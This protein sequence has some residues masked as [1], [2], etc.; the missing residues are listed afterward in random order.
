MTSSPRSSG[1]SL[2]L[3]ALLILAF[4]P[5]FSG[6]GA[7]ARVRQKPG[8]APLAGLRDQ[9]EAQLA[10]GRLKEARELFE[11]AVAMSPDD[12]RAQLELGLLYE[13]EGKT[14]RAIAAYEAGFRNPPAGFDRL[15][16]NLGA[17]HNLEGR[18]E[19]TLQLLDGRIADGDRDATAHLV[20]GAA[21]LATGKADRALAQ[22][23]IVRALEPS[24]LRGALAAGSALRALGRLDESTKLLEGAVRDY[25][26]DAAAHFQLAETLAAAGKHARA[27]SGYRQ[28]EGAGGDPAVIRRRMAD[29]SMAMK[30][31]PAAIAALEALRKG[32]P[33]DVELAGALSAAYEQAGQPAAAERVL[34]D[35][36][37][38][39][40]KSAP[41]FF[42]LGVVLGIRERHADAAAQF[43]KAQAL[44]PDDPSIVRALAVASRRA[45]DAAGAE[46]AARRLL[47]LRPDDV[48]STALTAALLRDRGKGSEAIALYRAFVARHPADPAALA[49]LAELLDEA[50]KGSEALEAARRAAA[51]GP[52]FATAHDRLGWLLLR[53]G[54]AASSLPPLEKAA[55]LSPSEPVVLYHYAEALHRNGRNREA[56]AAVDRALSI[57]TGFPGAREAASLRKKLVEAGRF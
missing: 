47:K 5:A 30:D 32:A 46:A 18:P 57:S 27:L 3:L 45:G 51:A 55:R 22:F 52:T 35:L 12:A 23:R 2:L 1:N 13:K 7:H 16:V 10:A 15:R 38:R 25:P 53:R 34:R 6:P 24:S 21:W 36:V 42:R 8:K 20:L 56:L 33:A 40:P 48:D 43:R 31:Y 9:A 26:K 50:G 14:A 19:K 39:A 37:A 54:D 44:A 11:K 29:V 4:G 28:A 41:A 49:D 17:L